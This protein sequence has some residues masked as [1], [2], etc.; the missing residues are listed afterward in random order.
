MRIISNLKRSLAKQ[1]LP[2]F[3]LLL[4]GR[5]RAVRRLASGGFSHSDLRMRTGAR[6]W[7]IPGECQPKNRSS[8]GLPGQI[9]AI[10]EM[11]SSFPSAAVIGPRIPVSCR[12]TW[13]R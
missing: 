7:F 12:M 6:E 9:V 8:Q 11:G 13:T 10:A 5:V 2:E 3:R 1:T 4:S